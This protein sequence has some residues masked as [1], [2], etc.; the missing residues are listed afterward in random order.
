MTS[1]TKNLEGL[2]I[3]WLDVDRIHENTD[4]Y[5]DT[6][7]RLRQCNNYIEIYHDPN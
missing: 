1:L 3:V 6:K 4:D 7:N 5:F 2:T